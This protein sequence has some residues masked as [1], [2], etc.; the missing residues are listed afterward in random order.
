MDGDYKQTPYTVYV[1]NL[2]FTYQRGVHSAAQKGLSDLDNPLI[3][4]EIA[5]RFLKY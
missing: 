2:N 1:D 3:E 5:Y 4:T